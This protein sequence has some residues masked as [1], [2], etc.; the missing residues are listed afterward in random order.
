MFEL[1]CCSWIF[2]GLCLAFSGCGGDLWS[3]WKAVWLQYSLKNDC[4]PKSG[5][6]NAPSRRCSCK[7]VPC[8]K[9][10][11]WEGGECEPNYGRRWNVLAHSS[12]YRPYR[13]HKV[14]AVSWCNHRC[15]EWR[16]QD[17]PTQSGS[18][19]KIRSRQVVDWKAGILDIVKNIL[20]CFSP[21]EVS[22]SSSAV[23]QEDYYDGI[24][25]PRQYMYQKWPRQSSFPHYF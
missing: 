7:S 21:S 14:A 24:Y 9:N 10:P 13:C 19:R 15:Q 11:A 22:S 5:R 23:T 25:L 17:I 16:W 6:A 2:K 4:F 8:H 12:S 3:N 20:L 18:L 1:S